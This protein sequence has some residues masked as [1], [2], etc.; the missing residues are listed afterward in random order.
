MS[1]PR[2]PAGDNS[3]LPAWCVGVPDR[4]GEGSSSLF[5]NAD[6]SHVESARKLSRS[7]L[8]IAGDTAPSFKPALCANCDL[9][10]LLDH[11][12][13]TPEHRWRDRE[14]ECLGGLEV[15]GQLELRGLLD[16]KVGRIR[17]LHVGPGARAP[18]I[19]RRPP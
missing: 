12:V 7:C 8:V 11:L 5:R 16:R 4:H 3:D 18:A 17:A 6:N 10:V 15:N 2:G 1:L 13:R 14:P 9:R 19:S